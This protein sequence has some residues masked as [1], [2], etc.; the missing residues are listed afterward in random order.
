METISVEP[1]K[2]YRFGFILTE[3]ELR[4]LI[5]VISDQLIKII[6]DAKV[7]QSY[8][9]KYQ[10]GAIAE[11]SSIDHVLAQ[12]NS[13]SA[14]IV[15]LKINATAENSAAIIAVE[16]IN[17]DKEEESGLISIKQKISGKSRDWVFVTSSLVQERL[18]K[19]KRF[20]PN[21][22]AKS[23]FLAA[24]LFPV[25]ILLTLLFTAFLSGNRAEYID[26]IEALW[27]KGTLKDPIEAIILFE[28]NRSNFDRYAVVKPII[29]PIIV[30]AVFVLIYAFFYKYYPVYNFC[31][32]DY[33]QL[34]EKT[35]SK[36]KF[37][38]IVILVGLLISVLG[39]LI[40]N[41]IGVMKLF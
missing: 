31:W 18:T 21:Q 26:K 6:P 5:G 36:R 41:S 29:Y 22:M 10:N 38:L 7:I 11:T 12:E 32:G 4:R 16:F 3:Q 25:F 39:S 37:W 15:R 23:K 17:A 13:G 24:L 1:S 2:T 19:I 33:L 14:Q 20:A 34:F 35:E 9:I 30:M 27:K 40:A 8:S 28:R